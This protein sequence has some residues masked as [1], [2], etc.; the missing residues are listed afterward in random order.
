MRKTRHPGA[1]IDQRN[2]HWRKGVHFFTLD[3]LWVKRPYIQITLPCDECNKFL[4][5]VNPLGSSAAVQW[6]EKGFKRTFFSFG[7]WETCSKDMQGDIFFHSLN[8]FSSALSG[9]KRG[10][11]VY[12]SLNYRFGINIWL[13]AFSVGRWS[14]FYFISFYSWIFLLSFTARGERFALSGRD[15][16]SFQGKGKRKRQ[17]IW[18]LKKLGFLLF[19]QKFS[20]FDPYIH[21]F[22]FTPFFFPIVY[23]KNRNFQELLFMQ[24]LLKSYLEDAQPC[25]F[26]QCMIYIP[27]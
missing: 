15:T 26:T 1:I 6:C 2:P 3:K 21:S 13:R 18:C 22:L 9:H 5:P 16:L 14:G 8:Y 27:V 7:Q 23:K 10:H 19:T 11:T 25:A 20:R 4:F 24:A 12:L 17:K